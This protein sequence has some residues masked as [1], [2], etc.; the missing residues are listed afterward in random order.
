MTIRADLFLIGLKILKNRKE[1]GA[2]GAAAVAK[3][4]GGEGFQ[5]GTRLPLLWRLKPPSRPAA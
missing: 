2:K 5:L 1:K 3:K 4:E